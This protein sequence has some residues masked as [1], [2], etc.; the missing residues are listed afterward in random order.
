MREPAEVS[1]DR[2]EP[3]LV[4]A[5]QVHLVH[6]QH[7][8]ADAEQAGDGGVAPG[9]GQHSLPRVDQHDGKLCPRR[10]GRHVARILLVAGRIG[11][12]EA[13]LAALEI[14][15]GDVDGD[16]LLALRLEPVGEQREIGQAVQLVRRQRP[17]IVQQP[18]DQG[19]FAVV[20]RAAGEQ[21][22]LGRGH[23]K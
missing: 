17:A 11:E 2:L 4:E 13:P 23:Q 3:A 8:G 6:R 19:R 9:L 1:D 18:A 5:D 21:A 15:I 10:A 7:E 20:D 22:E 12:D 16:A 14:E